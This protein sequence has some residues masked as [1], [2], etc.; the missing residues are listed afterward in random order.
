MWPWGHLAVG[1]LCYSLLA[2]ATDRRVSAFAV[3]AVAV[4]TQFPDLIDKPLAWTVAVLPNGRSLAH[5]LLTA[6][7]VGVVLVAI[8]RAVDARDESRQL[9]ADGGTTPMRPTAVHLAGAFVLG[10]GTH[11]LSDGLRPLLDGEFAALAYLGWPLLPAIQYGGPKSFVGHFA[12]MEVTPLLAL[13][14]LLVGVSLLV[15]NAD[16]RPGLS[17]AKRT[18]SRQRD[19]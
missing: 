3:V 8:A 7:V 16:G 4:G 10:Y 14:F 6:A 1:Y 12:S 5:S 2:R 15:W 17:V 13:Q 18:L 9:G 11:L 19:G